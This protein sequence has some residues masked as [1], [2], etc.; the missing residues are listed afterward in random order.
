MTTAIDITDVTRTCQNAVSTAALITALE[1]AW[2]AI[3]E[4]HPEVPAAVI[5]VGSGSPTK[6]N[7]GMKW[8]HFAALRWQ[9]GDTQLPEI[10]IS[11]EGLTREPEAVFTTL[12]HEATHALAD[13]RGIQDTSRQG[14]WHNKKF[15]TLAAELGMSTTK[16]DKL[17]YSPCTLTD[18][19]RARYKAV[20]ADLSEALRFYRHPEP[21]GEGKSR[22]NNN[23]GVSCEC[24]CPRKLRIS[25]AAFE[26]GPIVCA[27]CGAAFLPED[28]DRDTYEH[29]TFATGR[30]GDGQATDDPEDDDPMVFYDPTGERFGLPTYPFK[31]APDGLL[32]RRQLRDRQLRPGGQEPAAQILW[33]RGKRVAYL[34]RLDLAVPK[35]TATPAQRAAIDTALTA[36]RTCP[37]CRQVKP[38]YIPRRTGTCLDCHGD[39]R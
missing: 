27:T 20:I 35:R 16:D 34:F 4:R 30:A 9:A 12:L 38:Y 15:S 23:N 2:A 29:P 22:T 11:G 28:I 3:R 19:T 24:E 8:G 10:L 37:D 26:E 7:Q 39:D 21:T 18:L 14:R 17:G 36:R 32:T 33:R 6:P 5:V 31:F 13:V 1:S 25:K